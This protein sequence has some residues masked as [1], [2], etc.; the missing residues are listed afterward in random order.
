MSLDYIDLHNPSRAGEV[1]GVE[2]DNV[3]LAEDVG[4]DSEVCP[5]VHPLM[6]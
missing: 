4:V 5:A 1:E 3:R 2:T 6:G